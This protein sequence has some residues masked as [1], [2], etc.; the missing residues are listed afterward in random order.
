MKLVRLAAPPTLALALLAA[1]L[2]T[3]AGKVYRLGILATLS[4]T[5]HVESWRSFREGLRELGYVEGRNLVVEFRSAEGRAERMPAL[6]TELVTLNVDVIFAFTTAAALA[7]RNAT[8]TI[9]IVFSAVSDPVGAGLVTSLARPG[10]NI[11][12]TT[13]LSRDLIGK[14]LQLL[15]LTLPPSVLARADEVIQ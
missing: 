10:G 2:S 1:P 12:G 13:H 14:R 3:E 4:P 15:G 6:A 11:T 9:P 8:T 5:W 7:A